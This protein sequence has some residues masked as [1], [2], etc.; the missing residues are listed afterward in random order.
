MQI[1]VVDSERF[2]GLLNYIEP[3]IPSPQETQFWAM[4]KWYKKKKS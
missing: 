4:Q 3:S 1:N 2:Y